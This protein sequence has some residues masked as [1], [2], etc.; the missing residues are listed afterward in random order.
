M[1]KR[2]TSNSHQGPGPG[3]TG[4]RR[5]RSRLVTRVERGE[6]R[7]PLG[8]G[9][10]VGALTIERTVGG[11]YE[12]RDAQLGAMSGKRQRLW[13]GNDTWDPGV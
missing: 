6:R 3:G 4:Q 10:R 8:A 7:G 11:R 13:A 5:K 12:W 2:K 9:V 1:R